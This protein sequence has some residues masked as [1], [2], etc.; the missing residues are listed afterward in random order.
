[1][2]GTGQASGGTDLDSLI[3]VR[4][5]R[6]PNHRNVGTPGHRDLN[7]VLP[8]AA[9]HHLEMRAVVVIRAKR[10]VPRLRRYAAPLG[11]TER[12]VLA[13]LGDDCD[14]RCAPAYLYASSAWA[15]RS[16]AAVTARSWRSVR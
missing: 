12:V 3:S 16:I 6:E 4:V 14:G 8:L 15:A 11:M 7:A 10:K 5:A 13:V 2:L 9:L 1:M